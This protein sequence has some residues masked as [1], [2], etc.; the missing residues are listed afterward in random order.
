MGG[1]QVILRILVPQGTVGFIEEAATNWPSEDSTTWQEWYIDNSRQPPG[2]IHTPIGEDWTL[3]PRGALPRP[4]R[5]NP[6]IVAKH[7]IEFYGV[8]QSDRE[9]VF[10]ALCRGTFYEKP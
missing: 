3:F 7:L 2:R 1:R 10:E 8:N 6:P 4:R 5:Y 9:H